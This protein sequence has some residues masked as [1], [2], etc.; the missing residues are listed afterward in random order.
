M[1][2]AHRLIDQARVR[3]ADPRLHLAGVGIEDVAMAGRRAERRLAV[4]EMGNVAHGAL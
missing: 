3:E 2:G 1:G 4:D